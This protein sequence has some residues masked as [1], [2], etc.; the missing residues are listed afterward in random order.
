LGVRGRQRLGK[1]KWR[2]TLN[3]L[4]AR[5]VSA[6]ELDDVV[7]GGGNAKNLKNLPKGCRLGDNAYAFLGGYRLWQER[8]QDELVKSNRKPKSFAIGKAT[9]RPPTAGATRSRKR[10][11]RKEPNL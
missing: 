10:E 1:K 5:F 8:R 6:L 4:V 3:L 11:R 7:L 2:K 9:D